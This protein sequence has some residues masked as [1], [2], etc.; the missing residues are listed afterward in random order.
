MKFMMYH[1]YVQANVSIL[2]TVCVL[3]L[4]TKCLSVPVIIQWD[5]AGQERFRTITSSYYRGAHGIIVVYDTTDKESFTNVK[6]WLHEIDRYV[7]MY[8]CSN[9][10]LY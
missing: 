1:D 7:Y 6:A 10:S 3:C 8:E 9:K 4:Q 5:T 2:E